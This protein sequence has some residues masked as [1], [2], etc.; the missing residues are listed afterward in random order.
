[1]YPARLSARDGNEVTAVR[2]NFIMLPGVDFF[3]LMGPVDMGIQV[4]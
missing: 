2:V 4:G 3:Q 1:M